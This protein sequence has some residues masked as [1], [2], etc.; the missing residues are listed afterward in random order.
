VQLTW[1]C[2]DYGHLRASILAFDNLSGLPPWLS[3]T[4]CRLTSGGAFSTRPPIKTKFFL[5]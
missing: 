3:D 1:F 4:L 5:P 2:C